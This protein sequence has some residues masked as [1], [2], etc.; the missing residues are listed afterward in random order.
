VYS[1]KMNVGCNFFGDL[2][3]LLLLSGVFECVCRQRDPF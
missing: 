1:D 2:L 3:L